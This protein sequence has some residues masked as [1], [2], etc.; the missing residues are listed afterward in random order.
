MYHNGV[1]YIDY[2]DDPEG[3]ITDDGKCSSCGWQF[4]FDNLKALNFEVEESGVQ[5]GTV[6][7]PAVHWATGAITC[8]NCG[9][10]LPFVTSS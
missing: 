2:D 9:D 5:P 10:L 7:G 8:P 3:Y 1:E 6:D 4:D